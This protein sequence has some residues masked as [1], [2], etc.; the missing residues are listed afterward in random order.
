MTEARD[1][2]G[3]S[4]MASF[5]VRRST[6]TTVSGPK[7]TPKG[8][9]LDQDDP[10]LPLQLGWFRIYL[11][12]HRRAIIRCCFDHC[13]NCSP[14]SLVNRYST[15]RLWTTLRGKLCWTSSRSC[16]RCDLADVRHLDGI[17]WGLGDVSKLHPSKSN[18]KSNGVSLRFTIIFHNQTSSRLFPILN[19]TT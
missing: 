10:R 19:L 11:A 14:F 3:Y 6:E 4:L 1:P 15:S 16:W 9:H 2:G 8:W 13:S 17:T 5:F 18:G 12:L 7:L